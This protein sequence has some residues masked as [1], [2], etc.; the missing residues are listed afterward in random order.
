MGSEEVGD[1]FV[2]CNSVGLVHDDTDPRHVV[3]GVESD[4]YRVLEVTD[5]GGSELVDGAVNV[6]GDGCLSLR[7][8]LQ[9][10]DLD[11]CPW[12]LVVFRGQHC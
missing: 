12:V 9:D 4:R 10:G 6:G 8:A 1:P 11:L 7:V 3:G 5:F 2:V